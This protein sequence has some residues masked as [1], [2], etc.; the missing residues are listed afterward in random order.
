MIKAIADCSVHY[1][2]SAPLNLKVSYSTN[3]IFCVNGEY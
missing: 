1:S 3:R 2:S